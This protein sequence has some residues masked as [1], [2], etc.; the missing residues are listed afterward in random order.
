MR[1]HLDDMWVGQRLRV[2]MPR[3]Q[4]TIR[5]LRD[6]PQNAAVLA[7]ADAHVAWAIV[8]KPLNTLDG[9]RFHTLKTR[10]IASHVAALVFGPDRKSVV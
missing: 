6:S 7:A 5:K 9:F 8:R 10:D 4:S 1:E 3:L 2:E